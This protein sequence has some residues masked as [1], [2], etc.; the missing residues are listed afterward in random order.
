MFELRFDRNQIS[1]WAA[2]YE[3]PGEERVEA[4]ARENKGRGYLTRPEFLALCKWKTQ[5][6]KSRV[7]KNSEEFIR[8][9]TGIA[10]STR[11]E[12]LRIY[13]LLSLHG[14][15][16]PTASV[17]L[18]FWHPEPYPILDFRAL[19]SLGINKPPVYALEF[20]LR[21]T[22][23]CRALAQECGVTMRVLDRA[24]WQFSA[25]NQVGS[26]QYE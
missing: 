4:V 3:Y 12:E 9:A 26:S 1:F 6:T 22:Q 8:E 18:H 25:G 23:F 20:W 5:R 17:I 21:Y 7:A 14:V 11:H 2:Q 13:P 19:W 10:L 24:L 15:G 16:W